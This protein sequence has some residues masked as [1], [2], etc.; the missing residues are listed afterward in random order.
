MGLYWNISFYFNMFYSIRIFEKWL[1]WAIF[2]IGNS[3]DNC[4]EESNRRVSKTRC[5]YEMMEPKRFQCI[6]FFYS[7]VSS[8]SGLIVIILF[9][10]LVA[11]WIE[12]RTSNPCAVGSNPTERATIC[13]YQHSFGAVWIFYGIIQ[14]CLI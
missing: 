8:H 2:S 6:V 14:V 11:Q 5:R 3:N 7:I 13:I 4:G 12:H 9:Y 1:R 10:A